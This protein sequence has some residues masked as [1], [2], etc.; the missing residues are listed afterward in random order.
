MTPII[1][2][3]PG[4]SYEV[5]VSLEV[6]GVPQVLD[7]IGIASTVRTAAGTRAWH[8][9]V[10][11]VADDQGNNTL[12]A[13]TATPAQTALV[14]PARLV[15]DITYTWPDGTVETSPTFAIDLARKVLP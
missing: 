12:A 4:D 6:D 3:K 1:A 14:P 7:G 13:L 10:A 15:S 8:C 2:I 11:L 9:A 5:I